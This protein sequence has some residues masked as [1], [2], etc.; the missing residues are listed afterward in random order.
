MGVLAPILP[1][2]QQAR[3]AVCVAVRLGMGPRPL[4]Q[5]CITPH[6]LRAWCRAG[7]VAEGGVDIDV[8]TNTSTDKVRSVK[9]SGANDG[10]VIMSL[11]T[12]N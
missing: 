9:S 4:V 5:G 2:L 12:F 3:P 6:P 10:S 8:L 7:R 1:S 11:L